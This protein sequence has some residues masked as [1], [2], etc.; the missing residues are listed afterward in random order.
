MELEISQMIDLIESHFGSAWGEEKVLTVGGIVGTNIFKHAI[1]ACL[2][3]H[4]FHKILVVDGCQDYIGLMRK[5][6]KNYIYYLNLFESIEIP[7]PEK[8][9]HPF[10]KFLIEPQPGFEIVI[11][12]EKM[13]PYE[14]MVINN[15]HL[16]PKPYLSAMQKFFHGKIVCVVDPLDICGDSYIEVP[17]LYDSLTKQTPLHA[18]ARS[19]YN[20]DTRAIDRKIKSDFKKVKV[21]KRSIGKIDLTQYVTN[22]NRIIEEVAMRQMQNAFRRNQKFIVGNPDIQYYRDQN[23]QTI[24]VGAGT[25]LSITNVTKPLM[26]LR[27]HSSV[28]NIYANISYIRANAGLLVKPGNIISIEDACKHR[29]QSSCV[30]LGEEPMTKRLW[31][32][33]M[34]NSNTITI[35]DY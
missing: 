29:F 5:P 33:I 2:K 13:Y 15:A 19:M 30:V 28:S 3:Y 14:A 22:S 4:A 18:M 20:I 9:L 10:Y 21:Q 1:H 16:I 35:T 6:L 32:S 11:S 31:Y 26:K 7:S 17:T 12:A 24:A 27:I 25:M 23:E 8:L 34:K